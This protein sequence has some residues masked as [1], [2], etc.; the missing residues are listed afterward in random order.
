[1][2]KQLIKE[3]V[4]VNKK[5]AIRKLNNLLEGFINKPSSSD[6]DLKKANILSYWIKTYC[7][8]VSFEEKFDPTK[9]ISY[10][11][12]DILKVDF[13]FR[14]GSEQGGRHYAVVVEKNNPHNS[15]VITVIPLASIKGT[16]KLHENE[17]NLG[18]ELYRLLK[19]KHG[20]LEKEVQRR[21]LALSDVSVLVDSLDKADYVQLGTNEQTGEEGI[22]IPRNELDQGI[23]KLR[24]IVQDQKSE[25][26][27]KKTIIQNVAA[28]INRMKEGSYAL[29]N[30]ITTISKIRIVD[31]KESGDILKGIT[32]SAASMDL[33]NDKMKSFMIF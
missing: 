16:K 27:N 23:I 6:A 18:D 4:I 7:N 33:I 10:K 9:N 20:V 1:M 24:Q 14:V 17:V 30:Q 3:E 31:P 26:E 2:S 5:E 19:V 8:M 32:L 22:T 11:R 21:E 12:G 28:E 29:I 25:I 13:G 15:P